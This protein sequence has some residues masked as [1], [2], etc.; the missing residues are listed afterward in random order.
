MDTNPKINKTNNFSFSKLI[1]ES[2]MKFDY[3]VGS[4]KFKNE[5]EDDQIYFYDKP[6]NGKNFGK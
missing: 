6:E 5:N 1:S 3:E 4:V 2:K